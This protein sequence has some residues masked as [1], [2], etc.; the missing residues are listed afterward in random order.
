MRSWVSHNLKSS[1]W[2]GGFCSKTHVFEVHLDKLSR[3]HAVTW[4]LIKTTCPEYT[5]LCRLIRRVWNAY[6]IRRVRNDESRLLV[7]T[8]IQGEYVLNT[9]LGL[10]RVLNRYGTDTQFNI[11]FQVLHSMVWNGGVWNGIRGLDPELWIVVWIG[12]WIGMC[13][14][15]CSGPFILS[16][17]PPSAGSGGQ[18]CNSFASKQILR[19]D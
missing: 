2:V 11:T 1:I 15:P 6:F 3:V 8:M 5:F 18:R 17:T 16:G 10:E 9:L 13:A 4:L 12:V 7:P 19:Q 14:R